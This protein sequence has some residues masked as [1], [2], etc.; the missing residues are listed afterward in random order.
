MPRLSVVL[1]AWQPSFG[2]GRA[3][4]SLAG[5]M[6][7]PRQYE[8][9]VVDN[10][11]H[12][13]IRAAAAQLMPAPPFHLRVVAEP[14]LGL[15]AARNRGAR[16]AQGELIAFMD[17]DGQADPG[18]ASA[19]VAAFDALPDAV[20]IGGPIGLDRDAA[21]PAWWQA[22]FN[23]LCGEISYGAARRKLGYPRYPYGGNIAFRRAALG[24]APFSTALGRRGEQQ[25]AGEEFEVC[26]RLERAGGTIYYEPEAVMRHHLPRARYSRRFL[27]SRA[28]AHGRSMAM[29]EAG[30]FGRVFA[31]R[32]SLALDRAEAQRRRT[33]S[34]LGKLPTGPMDPAPAAGAAVG[35]GL[36]LLAQ[37]LG[38]GCQTFGREL[39]RRTPAASRVPPERS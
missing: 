3:L 34:R 36:R 30:H 16:E 7:A 12:G 19:L 18:W 4:E 22:S 6:L 33:A 23:E 17:D 15:S 20:C 13:A 5:Q 35:S 32:R 29:I 38:Y 9:L 11:P 26:L 27:Y 37:G 14:E 25:L 2:L 28:F 24:E 10:H 21:P 31:V 39:W 8:V 1:C